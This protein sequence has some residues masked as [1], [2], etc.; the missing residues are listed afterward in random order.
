[1]SKK[2]KDAAR[3]EQVLEDLNAIY[4]DLTQ[5]KI[6]SDALQS[7]VYVQAVANKIVW[8]LNE[9]CYG[10]DMSEWFKNQ[11]ER[12]KCQKASGK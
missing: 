1:M 2:V 3:I 7:A 9:I 10:T 6:D 12:M 5:G 8:K 4:N 11:E